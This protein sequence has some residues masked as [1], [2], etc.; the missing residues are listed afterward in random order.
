MQSRGL[1]LLLGDAILPKYALFIYL[2]IIIIIIII[3]IIT[4]VL[5][6]HSLNHK[7]MNAI[8]IYFGVIRIPTKVVHLQIRKEE[9]CIYI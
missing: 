6:V 3:T 9:Q 2:F 5:S 4:D 7:K 8:V 1:K